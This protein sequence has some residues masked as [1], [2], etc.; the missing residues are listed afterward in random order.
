MNFPFIPGQTPSQSNASF[1]SHAHS[2]EIASDAMTK[3]MQASATAMSNSL[4]SCEAVMSFSQKASTLGLEWW[5]ELV[6][7]PSPVDA[8]QVNARYFERWWSLWRSMSQEVANDASMFVSAPDSELTD[9]EDVAT[10]C[11]QKLYG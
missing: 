6:R 1:E 11:T 7:C 9:A 8:A 3:A 10:T 4:M 5:S 2:T